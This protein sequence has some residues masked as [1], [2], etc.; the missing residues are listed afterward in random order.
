MKDK[1]EKGIS[2]KRKGKRRLGKRKEEGRKIRKGQKTEGRRKE[3]REKERERVKERRTR[4]SVRVL[5]S[6]EMVEGKTLTGEMSVILTEEKK[7]T[8]CINK[9]KDHK[10]NFKEKHKS[11]L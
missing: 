5:L 7:L 10:M 3:E 4:I 8:F 11:F 6:I 2:R 9:P 1:E